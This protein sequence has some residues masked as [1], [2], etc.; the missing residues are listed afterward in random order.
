MNVNG[1][2][3]RTLASV[4]ARKYVKPEAF[5]RATSLDRSVVEG[6]KGSAPSLLLFDRFASR[7][8]PSVLRRDE[9][10]KEETDEEGER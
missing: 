3:K 10:R 4:Y 2:L 8:F 5:F 1:P 6:T 9:C 7:W